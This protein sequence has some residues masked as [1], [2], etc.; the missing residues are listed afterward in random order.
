M[1]R[2]IMIAGLLASASVPAMA[3]EAAAYTTAETS[4][5]TLLDDPAAKA[6]LEKHL[7]GMAG[8]AQIDMARGMTLKQVQGFAPDQF[9]DELLAKI[10]ADLAKL[11]AKK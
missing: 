4:I 11:P 2:T 5:G 9:S 7:P 8:N 3:A 1:L 10:D 6:I